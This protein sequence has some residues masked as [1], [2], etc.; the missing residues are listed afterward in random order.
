M[1][2]RICHS[3][4]NPYLP[5]SNHQK[6]CDGCRLYGRD[7]HKRHSAKI[8]T[9]ISGSVSASTLEDMDG[10]SAVGKTAGGVR[11]VRVL[12]CPKDNP[13]DD[14]P[15]FTPGHSKFPYDQFLS[16]LRLGTWPLG[17]KVEVIYVKYHGEEGGENRERRVRVRKY[18]I[19]SRG[20][21]GEKLG[22]KLEKDR[23]E[24]EKE[25]REY[26]RK[27]ESRKGGG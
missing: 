18:V 17:M 16:G 15:P 9:T 6:Y 13:D 1:D 8:R 26:F 3:C 14:A 21:E 5:S 2:N 12:D 24:F 11:W 27:K 20:L 10:R 23:R 4:S 22:D 7:E 19:G 25:A